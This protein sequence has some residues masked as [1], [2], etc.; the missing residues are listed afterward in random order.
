MLKAE[1]RSSAASRASA[2]VRRGLTAAEV[3]IALLLVTGGTLYA[4]SYLS[5]VALEKGFD[6]RNLAQIGFTIPLFLL[7]GHGFCNVIFA[8]RKGLLCICD[9]GLW[10][11]WGLAPPSNPR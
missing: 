2:F 8:V 5:L 6:S 7:S 3:A 4:R 9:C 11:T 1:D 10:G